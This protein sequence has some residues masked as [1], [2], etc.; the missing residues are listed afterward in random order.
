M[1]TSAP[2]IS[3]I[4]P[5][6]NGERYVREALESIHSQTYR[7]LEILVVDDG[8]TDN[9]KKVVTNLELPI[10]YVEQPNLGPIIARNHG[11]SL[12]R[13][14]F[15]AFL[16]A[17][18]LW[19]QEKLTRQMT[20]FRERPK[21]EV[22][23]C[24]IQNFWET[25]LHEEKMKF[26]NDRRS[27]PIP[28]YVCPGMVVRRSQFENVGLFDKNLRHASETDWFLRAA[29][30]DTVIELLQET[31]VYRRLHHSN[32]SR[33]HATNSRDEYLQLLQTHIK[34]RRQEEGKA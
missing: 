15:V 2:L 6:F 21:L 18:D 7:P 16:D 26:Q 20:Q 17:D 22:S 23:V 9:T 8:S 13:G 32:R 27:K 29:R 24:L 33:V 34:I 19:H 28:G 31:L 4:V 12:A 11:I 5:V 10:Q 1:E 3:C 14:A 25:E 30:K